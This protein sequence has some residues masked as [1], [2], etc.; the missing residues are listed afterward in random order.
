[1]PT[2]S[3]TIDTRTATATVAGFL[4]DFTTAEQWD[5]GT[6]SCRR[7]GP[8]DTPVTVGTRF[9]NVSSFR[10]RETSLCYEVV[11]LRPGTGI[12]LV[13]ENKTVTSVDDIRFR[14]H[15][16]GTRVEYQVEF[17]FKGLARLAVPFLK[18]SLTD[19]ADKG[20]ARMK[21]VLDGLAP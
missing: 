8:T 15:R 3:R 5:P 18:G 11:E 7:I 9:E 20:A 16:G 6:V 19:L 17:R 4:T 13:G 2:L 12:R 14:P 21:T 10:G 1:M